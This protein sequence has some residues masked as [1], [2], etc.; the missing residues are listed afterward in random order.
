MNCDEI[1]IKHND[2]D[3]IQKQIWNG[4]VQNYGHF[5]LLNVLSGASKQRWEIRLNLLFDKYLVYAKNILEKSMCYIAIPL[6]HRITWLTH[7]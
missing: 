4:Y 7:G 1:G 3:L 5:V 6:V 2:L